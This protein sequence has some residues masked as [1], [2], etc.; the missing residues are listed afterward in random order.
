M[1]KIKHPNIIQLYDSFIDKQ[2]DTNK[3]KKSLEKKQEIELAQQ[4]SESKTND[5][6]SNVGEG[7]NGSGKSLYIA[8]EYA[9]A[10]D[11]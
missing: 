9:E 1:T 3:F 7:K 6:I 8:M 10:G 11:M 4:T 2:F 5:D